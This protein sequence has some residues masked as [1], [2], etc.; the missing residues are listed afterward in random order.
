M[1]ETFTIMHVPTCTL[2]YMY[3]HIDPAPSGSPGRLRVEHKLPTTAELYWS[4][5]PEEKRNSIIAGYTVRVV[6]PDSPVEIQVQGADTTSVEIPGLRPSTSYTF[7]VSA[8]TNTGTG[9]AATISS[10][11]PE[12]GEM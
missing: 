5:V 9:P 7:N 8:M 10:K 12:G 2:L 6:G 3:T 1:W 4:P 11:T